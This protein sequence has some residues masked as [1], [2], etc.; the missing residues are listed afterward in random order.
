M[1][2]G[3]ASN[4][5]S[6]AF[7]RA[8]D[9]VRG[10]A[11]A[12]V[13]ARALYELLTVDER[14]GLLD[15]DTP[16]WHALREAATDGYNARPYEHGEVARTPHPP[17][18]FRRRAT[19]LCVGSRDRV[20]VAMAR[21]A[22]WDLELEE[23]VGEAIGREVRAQGGNF[24]GGV[25]INLLR[26]AAWGRAEETLRRRS[27]PSRR[28]GRSTRPG[29][30]SV[31]DGVRQALALNSVENARFI[32][33][34]EVDEATLHDVYLPH[35]KR[36]IDEGAS[37]VM[38]SYNSVN[39]E[40]MGRSCP[41]LTGVLRDLWQFTGMTAT[42]AVWGMRNGAAALEAGMDL[43]EL[44]SQTHATHLRNHLKAG[45]TSWETVERSGVRIQATQLRSYAARS[46]PPPGIEL[47]ARESHRRWRARPPRKRW[48]F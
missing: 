43:E 15:E 41:M 18:P 33:D 35:L 28:A 27:G 45:E 34:V 37:A 32:V 7:A 6:Q 48:C 20:P 36:V 23:A 19:W 26:H 44:F 9:A 29:C 8:V 17:H 2:I 47:M 14:L 30:R 22:T 38:A 31:R 21:G 42:D 12:D 5:D 3:H 40:W 24:L 16:L 11:D 39:G 4:D 10:G 13:G 25:C 46:E 1:S